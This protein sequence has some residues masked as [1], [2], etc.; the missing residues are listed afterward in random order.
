MAA[1][2]W[3]AGSLS[4]TDLAGFKHRQAGTH[5]SYQEYKQGQDVQLMVLT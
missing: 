1:P 3:L 4:A 2:S 5:A